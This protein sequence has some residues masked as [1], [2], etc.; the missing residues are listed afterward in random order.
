MPRR[1][2][3]TTQVNEMAVHR[4]LADWDEFGDALAEMAVRRPDGKFAGK[5]VVRVGKIKG[6]IADERS[7]SVVWI[8]VGS[9]SGTGFYCKY[10]GYHCIMTNN[11]VLGTKKEAKIA[12]CHLDYEA[13]RHKQTTFELDPE[14]FWRTSK[15]LDFTIVKVKDARSVAKRVPIPLRR[16]CADEG[17][18]AIVIQHPNGG[19]KMV[20]E[21]FVVDTDDTSVW[22]AVDTEFGSSGSPVFNE[23]WE[24]IALHHQR[25]PDMMANKGISIDAILDS[26]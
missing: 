9:G 4:P 20:D 26:L 3:N 12:A 6:N 11:H 13:G 10:D 2:Q 17:D 14:G 5:D 15:R 19:R 16:C 18:R 22:Y 7:A 24:L 23:Y 21:G 1:V 25:D 8:G